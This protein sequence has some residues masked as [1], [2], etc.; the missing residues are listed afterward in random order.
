MTSHQPPKDLENV[1]TKRLGLPYTP[2]ILAPLAGVS[3]HPFRRACAR[4]G[5]D[6][7]YVEM[8]S[9]TA[10]LFESRRTFDMLKRH[11]SESILGVQITGKTADDEILRN[12]DH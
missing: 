4:H 1:F 2:V 3:D 5:A 6:L 12:I 10:M 11:E 9:A 7:T 8:I